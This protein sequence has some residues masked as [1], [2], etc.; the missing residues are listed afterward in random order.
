MSPRHRVFGSPIALIL[1]STLACFAV[2]GC[3]DGAKND[4]KS[5]ER[6]GEKHD[7]A[8][9]AKSPSDAGKQP[10]LKPPRPPMDYV[11]SEAC[12]K[13]HAE[14]LA[15]YRGH[16]MGRSLSR[17]PEA[18]PLETLEGDATRF[19]PPGARSYWVEKKGDSL[20]H[21]EILVDLAGET[22]YDQ[23]EPVRFALGSGIRGRSYLIERGGVLLQSPIS[24]YSTKGLWDLSPTYRPE[25][26]P[27]F[28][29]RIRDQCVACHAGR[30]AVASELEEQYAPEPF[31]ELAV[32]CERCHGPGAAH[33]AYREAK[34]AG[35]APDPIVQPARLDAARRESVCNQCHLH[36]TIDV[37]RY[38]RVQFDFRPGDLVEDIRT[39]FE[40][41]SG[42]HADGTTKSVSQVSQMRA[43]KC[44][45]ASE[46]RLGC[47]SCHDP[48]ASPTAETRETFYRD[49]CLSCHADRGCS[50][51]EAERLAITASDSCMECHM[52][53]LVA[54][55][56]AH[57]AQTDHRVPRRPGDHGAGEGNPHGETL[58]FMDH[59]DER[60]APWEV[61][62]AMGLALRGVAGRN[63]NLG[64][65]KEAEVLLKRALEV[66]FDDPLI[67]D[68]LAAIE[69]TLK[70]TSDAR[71]HW[72]RLLEFHPR[73]ESALKSLVANCAST[74]DLEAALG[75]S[76]RLLK[77]NDGS[78]A[79]HARHAELLEAAKR[80]DEA[81][82]AGKRSIALD[83]SV[84]ATRIRLAKLLEKQGDASGSR[85]Q[86]E[87]ARRIQEAFAEG[88]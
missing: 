5:S 74:R 3:G 64:Q 12:G 61:D 43:S 13:C 27:R 81:I 24:W 41:G 73:H 23:A 49:R 30:V 50:A 37:L 47:I 76:A 52:P 77:V 68:G 45:T 58:T 36:G 22:V 18:K 51:P 28:E 34:I 32:G 63:N 9:E 7:S 19:H 14:L 82:A 4:G 48:H 67:L 8:R 10:P 35:D 53:R 15:S 38:G 39:V 79:Y 86:F 16:P 25:S 71:R 46:G 56:I 70:R 60:M 21:H 75:Y 11:G 1:G 2:S 17:L 33:V 44:Y 55:D 88:P 29:R 62:R 65:V 87:L 59:A 84:V 20:L 42:V 54:Q 6:T 57:A 40:A 83:P 85:E 72:E 80:F 66:A 26:H 69:Q 31:L 78:A